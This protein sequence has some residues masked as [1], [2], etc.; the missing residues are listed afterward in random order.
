MFE[1]KENELMVIIEDK[2]KA[3]EEMDQTTL[4]TET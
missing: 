4:K 1:D 2:D 3:L